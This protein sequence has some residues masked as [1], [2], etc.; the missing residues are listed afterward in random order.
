MEQEE[1]EVE[2][3]SQQSETPLRVTRKRGKEQK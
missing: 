1:E 3:A 2:P